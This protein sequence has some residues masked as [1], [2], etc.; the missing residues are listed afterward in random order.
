MFAVR[1]DKIGTIQLLPFWHWV[2]HHANPGGPRKT[3]LSL[4][5]VAFLAAGCGARN[6]ENDNDRL[7]TENLE[8][9][10]V[11]Q[12]LQANLD[13]RIGQM[14]TLRQKLDASADPTEGADPPML[15]KLMLG[16]FSGAVDTDG[17]G[18]DDRL[19]IY[20]KPLD[21]HGRF[22]PVAARATVQ[23][24]RIQENQPA[25]VLAERTLTPTQFDACYQ[26]GLTGTHYTLEIELPA[27]FPAGVP[28]LTVKVT[29]TEATSGAKLTAEQSTAIASRHPA[30]N[31]LN[32]GPRSRLS[33][34]P[35]PKTPN[36]QNSEP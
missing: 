7:R 20:L 14:Q 32:H 22:M 28:Q 25:T 21:Q 24:V 18:M 33:E 17:D 27:P 3:A 13:L 19:R 9:Q 12:Q 30:K 8:L 15:S 4:G 36:T 10:R 6:F 11:V 26:S 23:T 35:E 5:V 31:N 29:L 16:R 2:I 1:I 34:N